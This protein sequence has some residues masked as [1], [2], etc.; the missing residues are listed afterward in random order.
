[1]KTICAILLLTAAIRYSLRTRWIQ[2]RRLGSILLQPFRN[3]ADGGRGISA[4][5]AA[6]TSLAATIGTGNIAGV[7]GAVLLGGPGA[8]FWIWISGLL[9]MALKYTEVF[10]AMRCRKRG[11]DGQWRGGPM[12]WIRFALPKQHHFLGIFFAVCGMLAALG[13]GDLIQVSS[14]AESME[15]LLLSLGNDASV[16]SMTA[17]RLGTG[18]LTAGILFGV[19]SGGIRRIGKVSAALV[20]VMSLV[21]LMLCCIVIVRQR[22]ILSDVFQDILYGAFCPQAVLG[23]GTGIGFRKVFQV[24]LSR[25]IFSHEAGLGTAAIAHSCAE[26]RSAHAQARYGA[27][28]VFFDVLICTVTAIVILASSVPLPYGNAEI[29]SGLVIDALATCFDKTA[30]AGI[31]SL[32]L[33]LFA[34]TSMT[35]FA[36]YGSR[37]A[38]YLFG[39]R[40]VKPYYAVFLLIAVIGPVLPRSRA[41]EVSELL[42]AMLSI[43]NL[44]A[45]SLLLRHDRSILKALQEST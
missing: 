37:C 22:S 9:G 21:Y 5:E 34:F 1:M 32:A 19:L 16:L 28:E 3:D 14:V 4:F 43:P 38:E 44:I 8:L 23:A 41:W 17:L 35:G 27:F 24:G 39:L 7:A 42:N 12:Y 45:M 15:A 26:N 18:I 30:A 13:M 40:A 10:L 33:M 25:G 36:L 29:N 31:I 6:A 11:A 2:L 20:P